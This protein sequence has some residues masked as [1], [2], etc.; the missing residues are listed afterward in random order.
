MQKIGG[1]ITSKSEAELDN[2]QKLQK[3]A[4]QLMSSTQG[5]WN[6]HSLVYLKR[7][8]LSKLLYINN[9]Y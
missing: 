4:M 2:N 5:D 8:T 9:L 7:Q 6:E 1:E 3:Y